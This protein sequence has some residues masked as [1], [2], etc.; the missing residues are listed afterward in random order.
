MSS[1][2]LNGVSGMALAVE[3]PPLGVSSPQ[4][5]AEPNWCVNTRL[6]A[7]A[8]LQGATWAIKKYEKACK[9]TAYNNWKIGHC[10]GEV[11][12]NRHSYSA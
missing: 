11:N 1:L 9:H 12:W 4:G 2:N 5:A 6:S 7:Q 8:A 3:G 10:K